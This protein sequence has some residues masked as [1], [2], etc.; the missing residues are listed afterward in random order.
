MDLALSTRY[1]AAQNCPD[2]REN[3]KLMSKVSPMQWLLDAIPQLS[4]VPRVQCSRFDDYCSITVRPSLSCFF[5]GPCLCFALG[6]QAR[7]MARQL[8]NEPRCGVEVQRRLSGTCVLT[9][10]KLQ[11]IFQEQMNNL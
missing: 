5:H 11:N 8:M 3:A 7:K 10:V 6:S 2:E 1:C 9:N 4:K